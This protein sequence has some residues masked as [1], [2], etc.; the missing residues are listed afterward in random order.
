[1]TVDKG[2]SLLREIEEALVY[3][4]QAYELACCGSVPALR[5]ILAATF[6]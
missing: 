1:M 5:R 6:R 4:V 2:G 3:L